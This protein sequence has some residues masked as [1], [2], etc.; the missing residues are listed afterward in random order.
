MPFYR[1]STPFFTGRV[2]TS[3]VPTANACYV[4]PSVDG[5]S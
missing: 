4:I 3:D 1:N 5:L 2:D